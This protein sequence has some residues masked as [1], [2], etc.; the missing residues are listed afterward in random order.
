MGSNTGLK[1]ETTE[2]VN[3]DSV[4]KDASALCENPECGLAD[5]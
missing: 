5:G 4:K 3:R 2:K 1:R